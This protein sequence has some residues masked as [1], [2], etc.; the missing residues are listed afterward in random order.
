MR[1]IC[2]NKNG[3]PFTEMGST[4]VEAGL[5]VRMGVMLS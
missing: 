5:G 3:E 2:G 4:M 1:S